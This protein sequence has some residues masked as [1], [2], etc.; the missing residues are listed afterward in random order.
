MSRKRDIRIR[1]P[2]WDNTQF[3]KLVLMI[4][5]T[6]SIC[7]QP[8]FKITI[9]KLQY[10]YIIKNCRKFVFW[11]KFSFSVAA[12]SERSP[13]TYIHT[14]RLVAIPVCFCIF[15]PEWVVIRFYGH[16]IS[17]WLWLISDKLSRFSYTF[18]IP[19]WIKFF[20]D[21]SRLLN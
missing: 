20:S 16:K 9:I 11:T 19:L 14:N 12:V 8:H 5:K 6:T 2:R 10:I 13:I 7:Q 21:H 4:P 15:T 18:Q 1:Q 3:E 17:V